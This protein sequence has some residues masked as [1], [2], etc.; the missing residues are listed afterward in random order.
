MLARHE[1]SQTPIVTNVGFSHRRAAIAS[2]C[3]L[4][5]A[6]AGCGSQASEP[7]IATFVSEET[8]ATT[9]ATDPTAGDGESD[10]GSGTT[11][12]TSVTTVTT[13][14]STRSN[15]GESE[16]SNATTHGD[17]EGGIKFDQPGY[18]EDVP[19]AGDETAG[20]EIGCRK[21]DFLFVVDNSASMEGEQ[22]NLTS[23][24][25]G[26]ISAITDTVMVEDFRVMVIDTDWAGG[27]GDSIY[28]TPDCCATWC[29]S[30]LDGTCNGSPCTMVDGCDET[31]GAGKT[32][33]MN[34]A[35]C[36]VTGGKRYMEMGQP[37][38]V[39]TFSCLAEVG[40]AGDGDERPIEAMLEAL[41]T[42]DAAGQCNE[43]FVRSDAILV[44][45]VITDE[46]D[47]PDDVGDGFDDHNSP[48][49]PASWKTD[50]LA[51]KGDNE[52][53]VV[54]LGLVGD[55]DVPGG[56]CEFIKGDVGAEPAP[57]LRQWSDS[58]AFGQWGS[59]CA[60]DY[61]AFFEQAVSV[62]DSACEVF[63]PPE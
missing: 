22:Q 47:D 3:A 61:A 18:R 23:S 60:A 11:G 7:H 52:N 8:S 16:T 1:H 49:D 55:P 57:R 44:V 29:P 27:V 21:V 6:T 36:G 59:V 32:E 37:D 48:G 20:G 54:V 14:S 56:T 33:D 40:T 39:G 51:V 4:Q 13:D 26:F 9:D 58:F 43:D 63:E 42:L 25:A 53:A 17:T 50:L 62:I 24:F 12:A 19:K 10:G 15:S 28:C 30:N 41:T 5:V 35:E 45:T 34:A 31:L 38:L 46:E 2:V